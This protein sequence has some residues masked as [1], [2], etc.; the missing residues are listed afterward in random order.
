M[1]EALLDI[2]KAELGHEIVAELRTRS[3]VNRDGETAF[4]VDIIYLGERGALS[5]E[6][7]QRVIDGVWSLLDVEDVSPV[8]SFISAEDLTLEAAE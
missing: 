5:I 7:K 8:V 4:W 6:S 3:S 2:V 1:S